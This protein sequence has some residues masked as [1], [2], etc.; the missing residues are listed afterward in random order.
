MS[1]HATGRI[2]VVTG[3][4]QSIGQAIARRLAEDGH[5]VAIAD[6][7]DAGETEA[8]VRRAGRNC[9]TTVCD[10][11]S[12]DSVAEFAR[13]VQAQLG[14]CDILVASAGIYP[15]LNFSETSW[16]DWRRVMSVNVDSLFHLCKVFLPGMVERRWGR[17]IAISSTTF[18]TGTPRFAAYTTSKG[19]VIGFVRALA[20]EVGEVGVTVNAIAPSLVRTRGTLAGPQGQLGWF[21][22]TRELQAIKRTEEPEDL[23]GAVSF[24]ASDDAAFITG[25][26]LPVDGGLA[27]V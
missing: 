11:A 21:E 13:Q 17:I 5:D 2:A 16:E 25:Q 26:T 6:L 1:R 9:L 24:F 4:A 7:L 27:R 19:A 10:I 12:A 23:V 15:V 14:A 20:T 3:G 18:H 8:I 22:H